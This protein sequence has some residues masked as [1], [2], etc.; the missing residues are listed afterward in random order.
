MERW[1]TGILKN[2]Y[3][4]WR[5][6]DSV[7]GKEK[8]FFTPSP[9]RPISPTIFY[10]FL[11]PYFPIPLSVFPTLSPNSDGYV[12]AGLAAECASGAFSICFPDD[13]KISLAIDFFPNLDQGLGADDRAKPTSFASLLIDLNL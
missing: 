2:K 8:S 9:R 1:N 5:N 7:T 12:R 6:G 11:S 10:I 3:K 13:V 4:T